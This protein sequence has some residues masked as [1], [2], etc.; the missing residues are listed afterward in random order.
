MIYINVHR[1]YSKL[2]QKKNYFVCQRKKIY[3]K[4]HLKGKQTAV[5]LGEILI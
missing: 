4:D 5:P 3:N 2:G 1:G